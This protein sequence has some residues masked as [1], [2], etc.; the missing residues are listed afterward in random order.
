MRYQFTFQNSVKDLFIVSMMMTY[1]SSFILVVNVV[2]TLA[3]ATLLGA[4]IGSHQMVMAV[5]AGIAMI[6]FPVIQPLWIYFR[7]RK[8][9]AK[10]KED[11]TLSF[12]DQE[13]FVKVGEKDQMVSWSSVR[14][15]MKRGSLTLV[16]TDAQHGFVIP[17]RAIGSKEKQQEF[18]EFAKKAAESAHRKK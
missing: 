12:T 5:L 14:S 18:Y 4:C 9:D 13:I 7:C 16:Y 3:M 6:Y 11:T 10:I 2:W 8:A 17:R 15:V 1:R